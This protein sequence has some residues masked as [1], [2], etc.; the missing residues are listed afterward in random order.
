MQIFY[1]RSAQQSDMLRPIAFVFVYYQGCR[2][3]NWF[4]AP[5]ISLLF[6][7]RNSESHFSGFSGLG[8]RQHN[9]P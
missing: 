8:E 6:S 1:N 5:S 2:A 7:A 3:A 4:Q 9:V